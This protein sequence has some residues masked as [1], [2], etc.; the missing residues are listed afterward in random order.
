MKKLILATIALLATGCSSI[1][2]YYPSV[3]SVQSPEANV[4]TTV[5][6]GDR[7]LENGNVTTL[8]AID[9]KANVSIFDGVVT[10]GTYSQVYS[11]AG[12]KVYMPI[13]GAG[14]GITSFGMPSPAL[15]TTDKNNKLCFFGAFGTTFC[16]EQVMKIYQRPEYSQEDFMQELIYTGKVGNKVRFSYREFA[17]NRSRGN[18]TVEVEYD[19]DEGNIVSY[20]GAT[21]EIIKA[22]NRSITYQVLNHFPPVK[23]GG[24]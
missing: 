4:R 24:R 12:H 14:T 13:K 21:I 18:F 22:T 20:K 8:N 11:Q 6:L 2:P 3:E 5:S 10:A 15:V 17:Q 7:M 16:S 1:T 9:V 23:V 19:L